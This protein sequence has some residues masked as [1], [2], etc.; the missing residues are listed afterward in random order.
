MQARVN[1]QI[2]EEQNRLAAKRA[3]TQQLQDRYRQNVDNLGEKEARRIAALSVNRINRNIQTA[4][5]EAE[6]NEGYARQMVRF[7]SV[8]F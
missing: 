1:V 7:I 5:R 3:I 2:A 4:K 8:K 6:A